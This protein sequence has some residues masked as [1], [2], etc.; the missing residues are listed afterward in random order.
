MKCVRAKRDIGQECLPVS[1][2]YCI[3]D[4]SQHTSDAE[5]AASIQEHGL[6]FPII[7]YP[8]TIAEWRQLA[9]KNQMVVF[10]PDMPDDHTVLQ[11][12]CGNKR[13]RYARELGYT[14]IDCY[15]TE[16]LHEVALL[17][18]QQEK[19]FRSNASS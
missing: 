17:M 7:A 8:T 11:V 3:S 15:V 2:L 9:I 14:H 5:V 13:L 18:Q 6:E 16:S 19:W 1:E 4:R 10:P 12:R